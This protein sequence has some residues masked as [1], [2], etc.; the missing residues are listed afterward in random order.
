MSDGEP[1]MAWSRRGRNVNPAMT[2]TKSIVAAA[3][4]SAS[5]GATRSATPAEPDHERRAAPVAV[6]PARRA[7]AARSARSTSG[8]PRG[9]HGHGQRG[10]TEQHERGGVAR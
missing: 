6:A 8:T 4:T 9:D 3:R 5:R 1:P 10:E 2:P 7:C